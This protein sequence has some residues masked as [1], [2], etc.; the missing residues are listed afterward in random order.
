M[1]PLLF[2]PPKSTACREKDDASNKKVSTTTPK[3]T[4]TT[5]RLNL[6]FILLALRPP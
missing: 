4:Q 6:P 2:S 5:Y 1:L 3:K